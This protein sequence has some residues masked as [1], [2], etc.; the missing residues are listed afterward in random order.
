MQWLEKR[1]S[2]YSARTYVIDTTNSALAPSSARLCF[3]NDTLTIETDKAQASVDTYMF[4]FTRQ[5]LSLP[6]NICQGDTANSL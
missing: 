6:A 4:F 5:S 2:C 3:R 1:D